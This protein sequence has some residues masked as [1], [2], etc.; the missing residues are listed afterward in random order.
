MD[1]HWNTNHLDE[2]ILD[3]TKNIWRDKVR[4]EDLGTS[5]ED[6]IQLYS[7]CHTAA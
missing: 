7:E 3:T 5:K 4:L 2:G 6:L 1:L